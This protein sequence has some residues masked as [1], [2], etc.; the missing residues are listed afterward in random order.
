MRII[1]FSTS[2]VL[3]S[4]SYSVIYLGYG[5]FYP[6]VEIAEFRVLC[7]KWKR[8]HLGLN[9]IQCVI[10]ERVG[11]AD[12]FMRMCTFRCPQQLVFWVGKHVLKM[13]HIHPD[14]WGIFDFGDI[15]LFL[16]YMAAAWA[17]FMLSRHALFKY[18]WQ[19]FW[20][21]SVFES[22]IWLGSRKEKSSVYNWR[23]AVF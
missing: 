7:S 2:N 23:K 11:G 12:L 8:G 21:S 20:C 22:S 14:W 9:K 5:R 3:C 4:V 19:I 16:T 18:Y 1:S 13:M 6:K 10:K 17:S 15:L